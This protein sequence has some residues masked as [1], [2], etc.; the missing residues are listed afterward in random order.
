M[1]LQT[2]N[3]QNKINKY[4]NELTKEKTTLM[5]ESN[6]ADE[7]VKNIVAIIKKMKLYNGE[8]LQNEDSTG[9]SDKFCIEK[10]L[11]LLLISRGANRTGDWISCDC[12]KS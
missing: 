3:D 8:E 1:K 10:K 11:G 9:S 6:M 12:H 5:N 4:I 2:I 7:D